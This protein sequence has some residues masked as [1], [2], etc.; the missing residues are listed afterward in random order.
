MHASLCEVAIGISL[1]GI[2]TFY[3]TFGTGDV[4]LACA[5][6]WTYCGLLYVDAETVGAACVVEARV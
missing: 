2:H 3:H 1:G 4:A 6:K 5:T